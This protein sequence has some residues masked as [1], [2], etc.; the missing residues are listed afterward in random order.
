M[1][2]GTPDMLV[3]DTLVLDTSVFR[4]WTCKLLLATLTVFYFDL[5]GKTDCDI[6]QIRKSICGAQPTL[7]V[8]RC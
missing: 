4:K 1:V 7:R 6:W 8:G 5:P 2:S 3:T